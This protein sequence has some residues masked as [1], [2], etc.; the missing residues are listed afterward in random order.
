MNRIKSHQYKNFFGW[1]F[2]IKNRVK[3]LS[4]NFLVLIRILFGPDWL[5]VV[6]HL[7][8]WA[9]HEYT[10]Y[11][12]FIRIRSTLNII[13]RIFSH[14]PRTHVSCTFKSQDFYF[15][16]CPF[17]TQLTH[18]SMDLLWVEWNACNSRIWY[19]LKWNTCAMCASKHCWMIESKCSYCNYSEMFYP[20]GRLLILDWKFTQK[21]KIE[22][23]IYSWVL[24]I[25]EMWQQKLLR[26]WMATHDGRT[27]GLSQLNAYRLRTIFNIHWFYRIWIR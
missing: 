5:P 16:R 26:I 19:E 20:G 8:H 17:A 3:P 11:K 4:H 10:I 22:W 9:K 6:N 13:Q 7:K 2:K 21:G 27:V 23:T 14:V 25:K 12:Y 1:D 15:Y 18:L 24:F